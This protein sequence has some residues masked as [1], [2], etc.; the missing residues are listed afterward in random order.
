MITNF[1]TL[2]AGHMDVEDIGLRGTPVN[3]RWLPDAHLNTVFDNMEVMAK[4]LDDGGW[5]TFWLAEHHFQREG[6]ECIP[7]ILMAA[8]HLAHLT[9]RIKI[10][11]AFNVA[12]M[13]HPLRLAEDYA[14][15]DIL[16]GGR[17]IFGV[18]R[19]YHSR[20]VESFGA[21]ILD[22]DANRDLF[23][24]QV[25]IIM[26]ALHEPSFSHHGQH[27]DI[28]PKVPYRGY[29]L[30][31]ITL[32]PRPV[33]QP[34]ECWQ[35]IV[36]A[37]PRGIEF[38]IKHGIKG[39]IGGGA[40]GGGYASEVVVQW[41]EALARAGRETELGEDLLIGISFFLADTEE[42][43]IREATPIFEEEMKMFPPLGFVP[44]LADEQIAALAD[45]VRAPKAGL[46]TLADDV[47]NGAALCGPPERIIKGIEAIERD[48]PGLCH[49]SLNL[50]VGT[51][52][53]VLR[54]QIEWLGRDVLPV[55]RSRTGAPATVD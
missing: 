24:E 34:V 20:E 9:S 8:I 54:D 26:K 32:V 46:P 23:E 22:R 14:T 18:A 29:E 1:S 45:P 38:M 39:V 19:G 55:L 28:P 10:G 3:D 6:Y 43:A 5:D 47:K 30:E 13:W 11:C 21:P 51:P 25:E 4:A 42:K 49:I 27:Y 52:Q 2:Y 41:R 31:E 40:A 36:S 12:P 48:L 33:N 15:A 7:N 17:T 50:P 35:P 37:S 44:G 16:T 53:S